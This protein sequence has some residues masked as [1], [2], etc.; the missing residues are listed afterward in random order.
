VIIINDRV[1]AVP[2]KG[3]DV[4]GERRSVYHPAP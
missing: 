2:E 3:A 1:R 4:S